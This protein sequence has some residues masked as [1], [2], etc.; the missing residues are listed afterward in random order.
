MARCPSPLSSRLTVA[1]ITMALGAGSVFTAS[2]ALADP[3]PESSSGS[4]PY[5]DP[6][7]YLVSDASSE[8]TTCIGLSNRGST[9]NGT[10][11]ILW[12]C[13]FNDDQFWY[14][15]DDDQTFR[16][17]AT[18]YPAGKCVG[19]ANKG[20]TVNGTPLVLW[21][22]QSTS[23]Q[24]WRRQDLGQGRVALVNIGS[25]KCAGLANG[26]STVNGTPLVLWDCHLHADQRWIVGVTPP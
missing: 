21:D 19:L 13:H 16:S 5:E 4:A 26:G 2:P 12:D 14:F 25:G 15:R 11:L 1:L 17:F 22:C 24:R 9:A 7:K 6:I 3:A 23:D 20:S 10:P 18:G 8:A